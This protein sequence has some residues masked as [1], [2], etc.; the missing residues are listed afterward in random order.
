MKKDELLQKLR[1]FYVSAQN[2][3]RL[4][5]ESRDRISPQS[6][7]ANAFSADIL[8]RVGPS[9]DAVLQDLDYILGKLDSMSDLELGPLFDGHKNSY[10]VENSGN[11][12]K[13]YWKELFRRLWKWIKNPVVDLVVLLLG[14]LLVYLF[15]LN[16]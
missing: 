12:H 7:Y 14:A 16:K 4:L 2:F 5:L 13:R 6:V 1:L 9:L 10:P 11:F 8:L 3:R 15:G